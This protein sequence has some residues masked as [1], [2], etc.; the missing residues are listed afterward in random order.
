MAEHET[1]QNQF[2]GVNALA[3]RIEELTKER[4]EL[5]RARQDSQTKLLQEH[6]VDLAVVKGQLV[7]L[8]ERTKDLPDVMKRVSKL[9][10]WKVYLAGIV[11]SVMF[12]GSLIGAMLTLVFRR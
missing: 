10:S 1:N 6:G 2:A 7:L 8:V 12:I 5:T 11:S 3:K 9:E 4:D